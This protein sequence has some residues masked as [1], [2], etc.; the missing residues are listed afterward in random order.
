MVKCG[1]NTKGE[2]PMK[3]KKRF[4]AI[5]LA[6]VLLGGC[7][8]ETESGESK[9]QDDYKQLIESGQKVLDDGLETIREA[10]SVDGFE[11]ASMEYERFNSYASENGLDGT[12]VYIEGKVLNQTK[13]GDDSDF[14][15]LALVIEQ[16]DGNRW[17]VSI[18]SD[19]EIDGI[20]DK[21]VRVFGT[22]VGFSDVM[23]L[24]SIVLAVEDYDIMEKVK[25]EVNNSGEYTEAW[26]FYNDYA[27]A[28]IDKLD[29][30][31]GSS[32][33]ESVESET[34]E[35]I[36][37]P[38]IVFREIPWGTSFPEVDSSLA[39]W[40]LWNISGEGYKTCSVDDILIGDY[41]GIDFEY[42]GINIISSAFKGEQDVAG[43]KTSDIDLY[44]VFLPNENGYLTYD[45]KDTALYGVQYMFE[46][47][48]LEDMYNDLTEKLTSLYGEPDKVTYDT[49]WLDIQYTYT[50]WY[51]ANNTEL[52]LRSQNS[53][54]DTTD[55]YEDEIYIT[56]AWREGDNLL[57]NASD[58]VKK[59][60]RD[61]EKE[62]QGNSDVNGL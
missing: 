35:D 21:N 58:A 31:D 3:K 17:C 11:N 28:E 15:T 43:Y 24:P 16:E 56:Y 53:E 18:T 52:V 26:N 49:D 62:A 4:T 22:Y 2:I 27:K 9:T 40:D 1:K 46:P 5:L 45:E 55:L 12:L 7:G 34:K 44:F 6:V 19:S 36:E 8:S 38:E 48:D 59:E 61:K 10:Y 30:R 39:S 54:N 41:E 13:L 47:V 20:T 51:G 60:K 50:Y 57:K 14:P 42:S 37:K 32:S 25:I 33:K 23:N 29:N